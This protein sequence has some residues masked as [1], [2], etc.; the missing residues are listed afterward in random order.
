[1]TKAPTFVRAFSSCFNY[2][3][4]GGLEP[5]ETT[6]YRRDLPVRERARAV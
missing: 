5:P 3:Y 1:M 4:E 6:P 2:V